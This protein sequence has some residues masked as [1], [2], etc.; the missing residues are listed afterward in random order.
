MKERKRKACGRSWRVESSS[1]GTDSLI[2]P[3][4]LIRFLLRNC[5]NSRFLEWGR[6]H[7]WSAT[8]KTVEVRTRLR[9]PRLS[10]HV[11]SVL[12]T[13]DNVRWSWVPN[14]FGR[15]RTEDCCVKFLQCLIYVN[16]T[17]CSIFFVF[18]RLT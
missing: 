13:H 14:R 5:S 12:Y 4:T 11:T 3:V 10:D 16:P 9:G 2:E 1:T 17:I 7:W 15:G 8:C 6:C 18:F